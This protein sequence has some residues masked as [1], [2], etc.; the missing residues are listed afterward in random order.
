[1][2]NKNVFIA[3]GIMLSLVFLLTWVVPA[4]TIGTYSLTLGSITPTGFADIFSALDIILY[5]FAKPSILIL[6]VGMFYGVINKTGVYKA[7]VDKTV[8]VLKKDPIVFLVLTVLFYGLTTALTGIYLPMIIFI[9]FSI[10]VL[11]ELGYKKLPSLLATAGSIV[12]GLTAEWSSATFR[13]ATSITTNTYLWVKILLLVLSLALIV[14]YVYRDMKNKKVTKEKEP[15]KELVEEDSMFVPQTRTAKLKKK[16]TGLSLLIVYALLFVIFVLGLTPWVDNSVF[17]KLYEEI[18]AVQIGN[19]AIFDA[20]LGDFEVFGTWTLISV[21]VTLGVAI[22]VMS[23]TGGLKLKE[24]FESAVEGAK[25]VMGIAVVIALITMVV[26]FTL[27]SGF[28]ATIMGM[29]QNGNL[30]MIT[31]SGL[32][33]S[34]FMIDQLYVANYTLQVLNQLIS[35]TS[36]L[37]LY[38]LIYQTTYGFMM[39]LAPSSAI[40]IF[41]L[42]YV[43]EGYTDWFKYVWKFLFVFLVLILLS[44]TVSA[45]FILGVSDWTFILLF[46]ALLATIITIISLWKVYEKAGSKGWKSIVPVYNLIVAF[47][48]LDI[49][50]WFL[51][52]G[53]VP[54]VNIA[55]S[56]YMA[57]RFA[58]KFKKNNLYIVGLVLV[59]FVFYPMLA[60]SKDKFDKKA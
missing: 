55:A 17:S 3:L 46:L 56:V 11:L 52:I 15:A 1:M 23:I 9:P 8:S 2:K 29:V 59:P 27:N 26:I 58:K 45:K 13:T 42:L 22:I 18:V 41:G 5:Y 60:F 10:A 44:I 40:L 7:L 35:D 43:N 16:Q 33:T 21:F 37:E 20:I 47:R 54:G 48:F 57:I 6:F 36:A 39:L 32:L 25:K 19:F 14:F 51:A 12:V 4:S 50:M 30:G 53:L 31:F 49:P 34:P 24:V 28:L 38:N